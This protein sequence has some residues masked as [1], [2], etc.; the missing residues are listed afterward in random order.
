MLSVQLDGGLGYGL[1]SGDNALDLA[2]G[3]EELLGLM[4]DVFDI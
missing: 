3:A 4:D 1:M 2:I